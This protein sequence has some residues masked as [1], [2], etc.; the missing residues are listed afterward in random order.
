[1]LQFWYFIHQ[2]LSWICISNHS[3][4]SKP[5]L[6]FLWLLN[7]S[8]HHLGLVFLPLWFA[9]SLVAAIPRVFKFV[10]ECLHLFAAP[11]IRLLCERP[12]GIIG[13]FSVNRSRLFI[14][15]GAL[16]NGFRHLFILPTKSR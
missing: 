11:L 5:F 12:F 9:L 13:S 10:D 4:T 3:L 7:P 15:E 6:L 1:M 16:L 2:V 14:S 8:Y